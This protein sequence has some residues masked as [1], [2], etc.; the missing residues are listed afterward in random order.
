MYII[1][2]KNEPGLMVM[3]WSTFNIEITTKTDNAIRFV[4]ADEVN[5]AIS[6]IQ[7]VKK[8]KN[9]TIDFEI[10]EI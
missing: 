3:Y 7:A 10:V 2:V 8:V 4:T 9:I 1:T 6:M 5:A